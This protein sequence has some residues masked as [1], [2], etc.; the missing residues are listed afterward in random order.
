MT[1]SSDGMFFVHFF[2]SIRIHTLHTRVSQ[3]NQNSEFWNVTYPSG[4]HRLH[5]PPKKFQHYRPINDIVQAIFSLHCNYN[6]EIAQIC[7]QI[8]Q[9]GKICQICIFGRVKYGQVG[10]P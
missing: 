5:E 1:I 3:K 8:C 10:C 6:G 9:Y 4:F 7:T 2:F